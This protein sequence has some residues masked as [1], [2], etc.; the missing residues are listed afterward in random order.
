MFGTSIFISTGC[1]SS[2][3]LGEP[4]RASFTLSAV[5]GESASDTLQ[6]SNIGEGGLEFMLTSDN[7]AIA[8]EPSTGVIAAGASQTIAITGTCTALG[9]ASAQLT[10]STD[11]PNPMT[12]MRAIDVTLA[13]GSRLSAP[14]PANVAL[15]TE[16]LLTTTQTLDFQNRATGAVNFEIGGVPEWLTVT[17]A[18]GS[19]ASGAS[20]SIALETLC[21]NRVAR[22]SATLTLASDVAG[23]MVHNIEI[24][25]D[26]ASSFQIDVRFTAPVSVELEVAFAEAAVRWSTIITGDLLDMPANF[27]NVCN[28]GQD[29]QETVD[30]LIIYATIGPIDGPGGTLGQAGPCLLR[31][32]SSLPAVGVMR[33]DSADIENLGAKR[34]EVILHE[35]GHVLGAGGIWDSVFGMI[36]Y[37]GATCLT[38][39]DPTF[40][41]PNAKTE[42]QALGGVGSPPIENQYGQGTQCSHWDEETFG[43]EL[44]T[45]LI[46]DAGNALSRL[47]IASFRDIGY[48][49]DLDA[50]DPYEIPA[51][52]PNCLELHQGGFRLVEDVL[53]PIGFAMPNGEILPYELH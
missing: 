19:L 1:S 23:D 46:E 34:G 17:P 5:M 50:A 44:M 18:S 32:G 9:N 30:D 52:S 10:L 2:G 13:C 20:Q 37:S 51:C 28:S 48:L 7:A 43:T 22:E 26:C 49:V 3:A 6:F 29:L 4:D 45:G 8:V 11:D 27:T 15:D 42:Y 47:T 38:S 31:P 53:P 21:P 41:G 33:F 16:V 12:G 14:T 25:R 35:M 24:T 40:S 39:S 36:D